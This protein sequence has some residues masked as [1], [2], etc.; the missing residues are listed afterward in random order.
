MAHLLLR[1]L[2]SYIS[3]FALPPSSYILLCLLT[4]PLLLPLT[5]LFPSSGFLPKEAHAPVAVHSNCCHFLS[6]LP[7]AVPLPSPLLL[8]SCKPT[9]HIPVILVEILYPSLYYLLSFLL[10]GFMQKRLLH[11]PLLSDSA[12]CA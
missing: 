7:L 10:S 4:L 12:P 1:Y 3:T 6:P 5:F 11:M 2:I 9:A 8:F